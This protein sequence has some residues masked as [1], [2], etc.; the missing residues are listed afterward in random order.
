MA[1]YTLHWA[2]SQPGGVTKWRRC[3][4]GDRDDGTVL[5]GGP[6]IRG[7]PCVGGA[8]ERVGVATR[9]THQY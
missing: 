5:P 7:G 4:S 3:S 2:R 1:T 9:Q 8:N 6:V